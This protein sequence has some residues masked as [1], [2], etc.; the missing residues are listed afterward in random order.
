MMENRIFSSLKQLNDSG[1]FLCHIDEYEYE[2]LQQ[3]FQKMNFP[4]LGTVIWDK[5]NPMMGGARTS[6]TT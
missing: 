3:L 5:K 6:F 2:N 1:S 4:Y